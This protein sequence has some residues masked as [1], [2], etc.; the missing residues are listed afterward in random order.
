M[1]ISKLRIYLGIVLISCG[2]IYAL[3]LRPPESMITGKITDI[4]SGLPLSDVNVFLANTTIG[5]ASDH[6]GNFV[7]FNVPQGF[8]DLIFDCVGYE[9]KSIQ[10]GMMQAQSLNYVIELT[11]KIYLTDNIHV[12]ADIPEDWLENLEIFTREFIG[13][14]NFAEDCHILN[15]EVLELYLDEETEILAASTD[16]LLQIQNDAL[17][18]R[19]DIKL[20]QFEYNTE[21]NNCRY[22]IYPRFYQLK[23][24]DEEQFSQ[25]QENRWQAFK[26][27]LRHFL[28][29]YNQDNFYP[30]FKIFIVIVE[31]D[32]R[33]VTREI[34][35]YENML[36]SSLLRISFPNFLGIE[37]DSFN[38]PQKKSMVRLD[39]GYAYIDS[40]GNIYGR[41]TKRGDWSRERVA[42]L[43]PYDYNP[44]IIK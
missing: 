37:Y 28:Y 22:E 27:S 23:A 12:V 39:Q 24:I 15:P 32:V 19:M 17:G 21:D 31:N 6:Q 7:I 44:G 43:L 40:L 4:D 3:H 35:Q 5:A 8:Y 2:S 25:W 26:G 36:N 18:Y 16:S 20:V 1:L 34:I 30:L 14:G 41:I 9:T 11:P 10:V 13:Q 29:L 38:L 42:D 33:H